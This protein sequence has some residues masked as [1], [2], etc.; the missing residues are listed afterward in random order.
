[1]MIYSQIPRLRQT[2]VALGCFDGVHLGHQ[3]VIRQAADCKGE[4]LDT[5]VF[6]F[7]DI[8]SPKHRIGSILTW[9]DKCRLI[10]SMGI[11]HLVA[12]PFA[13]VRDYTPEAFVRD[14]L[15]GQLGA[16]FVTCGE[17]YRFGRHAAGDAARLR[18]MCEA[19]GVRCVI[20]PPVLY[21][22]AMISSTRIR[23]A[24][25]AGDMPLARRMLGRRFG[26]RLEVVRGRQLGRQLGAPTINQTFP[27]GFL[28]P[29]FGVYA[30]VA[31]VGGR[32]MPS[33]TNIGV[34]PT[35]GSPC[36]LSETWIPDFEGDLYGQWV[37]VEL[38]SFMRDECR[39]DS[40]EA[41][42]AAILRD[43]EEAKK[44]WKV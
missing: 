38:D 10:E 25:L 40:V 29:R 37:R 4:E 14:I 15:I 13:T 7:S 33:V 32:Q 19:A 23:N 44:K 28:L 6:C 24:V 41:L 2:A 11:R 31:E 3:A 34:K 18:E 8:P 42:K 21:E 9:D 36:P 43:G 26:Y 35:V 20:V 39:F 17:N 27:E 30:S 1:M 12:P 16:V 22:N 5:A